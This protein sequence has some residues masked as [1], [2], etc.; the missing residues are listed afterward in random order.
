VCMVYAY[1]WRQDGIEGGDPRVQCVMME[2]KANKG[3]G[4]QVQCVMMEMEMEVN[5]G[6]E[7]Q[8]L[9]IGGY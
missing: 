9:G 4:P 1:F 2:M 5:K 6:I 8:K 3:I 7:T